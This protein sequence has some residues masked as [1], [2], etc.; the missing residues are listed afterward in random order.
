MT[1]LGLG[2]D[3]AL[4]LRLP[5]QRIAQHTVDQ[6]A[7]AG[8]RHGRG[9]HSL[10]DHRVGL[11]GALRQ[12]L[13]GNQQKRPNLHRRRTMQQAG[14]D[15][16]TAPELAQGRPGE[17]AHGATRAFRPLRMPGLHALEDIGQVGAVDHASDQFGC[18]CER[19]AEAVDG[20]FRST[21]WGTTHTGCAGAGRAGGRQGGPSVFGVGWGQ[22]LENGRRSGTG[23]GQQG[24]QMIGQGELRTVYRTIEVLQF[25]D[26]ALGKTAVHLVRVE[27]S[28]VERIGRAGH[29]PEAPIERNVEE[30]RPHPRKHPT[31]AG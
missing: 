27:R 10:I 18:P 31:Q 9:A 16:I 14:K 6:V 12:A 3:P 30:V 20:L 15:R 25:A 22:G 17:V 2:L 23:S 24:T 19:V 8:H 4:P 21:A 13:Q 28:R 7:Q 26:G 11:L 29:A 5:T 1:R